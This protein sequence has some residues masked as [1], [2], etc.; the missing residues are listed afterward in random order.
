MAKFIVQEYIRVLTFKQ[1]WF[2]PC[3]Y[4]WP[5]T[6]R[7]INREKIIGESLALSM[8]QAK[9]EETF[10]GYILDLSTIFMTGFEVNNKIGF[11]YLKNYEE[12]WN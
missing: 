1:T 6:F 11:V 4:P 8:S 10:Q 2:Y 5:V 7:D 9:I 3:I 12:I